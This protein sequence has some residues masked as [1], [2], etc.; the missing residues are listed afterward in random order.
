MSSGS[1]ALAVAGSLMQEE[2]RCEPVGHQGLKEAARALPGGMRLGPV[3]GAEG[4]RGQL[5]T[6]GRRS[7]PVHGTLP[8]SQ[9]RLTLILT[10]LRP[11]LPPRPLLPP[12]SPGSPTLTLGSLAP[13]DG[14]HLETPTYTSRKL[15][16]PLVALFGGHCSLAFSRTAATGL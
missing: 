10:V 4:Q 7:C 13:P 8:R 14:P 9:G 5:A 6:G 2:R 16:C 11:P 15:T 3:M 1:P 12:A